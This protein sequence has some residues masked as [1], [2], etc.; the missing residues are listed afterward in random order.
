MLCGLCGFKI[1]VHEVRREPWWEIGEELEGREC[2]DGV[3]Q[4]VLCVCTK[5][6]NNKEERKEEKLVSVRVRGKSNT[7]PTQLRRSVLLF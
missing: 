5:C 2:V 6:S 7:T 3:D 4:N 1:K